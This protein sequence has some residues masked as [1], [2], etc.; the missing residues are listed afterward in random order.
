MPGTYH[1]QG[2]E[3]LSMLVHTCKRPGVG[4]PSLL[5]CMGAMARFGFCDEADW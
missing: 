5:G 3:L 2:A 1:G 4:D